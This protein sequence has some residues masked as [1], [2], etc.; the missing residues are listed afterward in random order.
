MM[1]CFLAMAKNAPVCEKRC[2]WLRNPNALCALPT[3]PQLRE[4]TMADVGEDEDEDE[5]SGG[6]DDAPLLGGDAVQMRDMPH[7]ASF[8]RSNGPRY[9]RA[10]FY[11]Y[12]WPRRAAV[13]A[14]SPPRL[15]P[16][17]TAARCAATLSCLHALLVRFYCG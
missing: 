4:P 6:G 17:P 10:D 13:R 11:G 12:W 3:N 9:K 5:E 7:G 14:S 15:P 1:P 2:V 8:S 16:P